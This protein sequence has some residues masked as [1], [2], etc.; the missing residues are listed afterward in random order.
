MSTATLEAVRLAARIG[1]IEPSATMAAVAEAEK[2]RQQG[3]DVVDC[4]AGEPHFS[5]PQ[6]IKDAAI[7]AINGNFTR[8]TAVGGTLELKD[9]I[10]R[11]HSEDFGSGYKRDEVYASVGGKH[12]L[13][14]AI[15]VLVDHGDEVILPV[16]YWV[17]FKDMVNYAG[18]KCVLLNADESQGFRVTAGMVERLVTSRTKLII[19]N[20]PSNPSGAVISPADMAAVVR[21]AHE[22]GI[23]VISDE[24]YVYL[25]YAGENFSVGSLNEYRERFLVV[26]SLSKTYAMTGWRLGYTLG[27]SAVISAAQKL[28]SQ[29]TSNP[30][31][32]V[33]KAAVA[34]MTG[35]QQCVADMRA[36]YIRLRNHIVSGVRSI[37]GIQ[38]TMPEGA[39][40]IYP[41]VS[42]YFGKSELRAAADVARGLLHK[43]HVA[44]V[45]GEGFGTT[46]HIR[47]SYAT[48]LENLNKA[49]QRMKDYFASL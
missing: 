18:G 21:L 24:C 22:R 40:Y 10:L 2:L 16:P 4:T 3:I 27:P 45:A 49:L 5:T 14:N 39:F 7:A 32:I 13:F 11:R 47:I 20:S 6:H 43:A 12:A 34:A 46:D 41:N 23:W 8:Y 31:S 1:R 35:S 33:Q 15:S 48:S 29:S 44:T 25:N 26:G 38:C 19:L 9:A 17:S 37:P 30:T 36:E 42:A 28:Q